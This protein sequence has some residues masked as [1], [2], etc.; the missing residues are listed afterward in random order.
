MK[1]IIKYILV[2]VMLI[3]YASAYG[4]LPG[5]GSLEEAGKK[6]L[7]V[8]ME[9]KKTEQLE[10]LKN[11]RNT[12]LDQK[13]EFTTQVEETLNELQ[14]QEKLLKEQ[15]VKDADN[16][17]LLK[18]S[19]LINERQSTLRKQLQIRDQII[20]T[21]DQHIKI[22]DEYLTDAQFKRYEAKELQVGDQL[23]YS[24][25]TLQRLYNLSVRQQKHNDQLLQKDKQLTSGLEGRKRAAQAT[26]DAFKKKQEEYDQF[27]QRNEN[28]AETYELNFEQRKELFDVE[29][30]LFEDRK[31]LD[32]LQQNDIEQQLAML[33][34][35]EFIGKFHLDLIR[36]WLRRV[37]NAIRI[38]ESEILSDKDKVER[39]H[40]ELYEAKDK[41]RYDRDLLIA[42][43]KKAEEKR[44]TISKQKNI[45][46]AQNIDD[47]SYEP[48]QSAEAYVSFLE[49]A[50]ANS[51]YLLL[52]RKIHLQD[53]LLLLEDEKDRNEEIKVE[54]KESFYI[55]SV[56]RYRSEDD[57]KQELKSYD[58]PRAE[59]QAN[60][61][62]LTEKR[63]STEAQLEMQKRALEN[64]KKIREQIEQNK[65]GIFKD[66]Q[67]DY[68]R[69]LEL[70]KLSERN[71]K[72]QVEIL[73]KVLGNYTD[74]LNL[75]TDMER[76]IQFISSELSSMALWQRPEVAIAWSDIQTILPSIQ[77][78][79]ND[80]QT[81]ILD[82]NI[83]VFIQQFMNHFN[84]PWDIVL[85]IIN[86]CILLGAFIVVRYYLPKVSRRLKRNPAGEERVSTFNL[87]IAMICDFATTYFIGLSVWLI[88]FILLQFYTVSN[89]YYYVL[90]YL[91][92]IP[93]LL[94]HGNRFIAFFRRFN[95]EYGYTFVAEDFESRITLVLSTLL[96]STIII[97]FFK[98]AFILAYYGKTK[99]P[100]ILMALNFIIFQIS[101]ILVLSKEQILSIIPENRAIWEWIREQ[102]DTYYYII[103]IFVIAMI[104]MSNPYVGFGFLVRHIIFR[105]LQTGLIV[106]VLYQLHVWFKRRI[107]TIFF[108][109]DQDVVRERF[110]QAKTW[111]GA[112]V[113]GLF[114]VFMFAGI[115]LFSRIWEW[116]E[117]LA[118]IHSWKD[119]KLLLDTPFMFQDTTAPIS[120]FS[121][122]KIMLFLII[123][124]LVSFGMNQFVL[125]KIF[126]VLLVD[127]GVQNAV[128]SIMRY[129]IIAAS[130]I[131]G[132]ESVG[133]HQ[134]VT[135]LLGALLVSLGWII[136][137][138]MGD[139]IAYFVILVQ[140]PIKIG[141][142]IYVDHESMGVVRKITA[143]SVVLRRRNSTTIVI[144]NSKVVNHPIVNWNYV[145]SFIAFDDI[146][147]TISYKED[148]MRVRELFMKVLDESPYILKSPRPIV[149]LEAFGDF[150]FTFLIRGFVSSNYT[151]EQWE[152]AS[153]VR[154]AMV[155]ALRNNNIEI[156]LPARVVFNRAD[157]SVS[158]PDSIALGD[159]TGMPE[160]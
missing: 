28:F 127:A 36:E 78:F 80:L 130:I 56:G 144:P 60:A 1:A 158:L 65:D 58:S 50:Y 156:A 66:N 118:E 33:K 119:I 92:S 116:P 38:S 73:S 157:K 117:R 126:N 86:I 17:F 64:I 149:R 142:Y 70:V 59:I 29:R 63:T 12:L 34:T 110:S 69:A 25:E 107:G 72:Q 151:L 129:I 85:L 150:G 132:L 111:Y 54:V 14:A 112:S 100:T 97:F 102:V 68:A 20:S 32:A 103:L 62:L 18:K 22:I 24:Y 109:I 136:K 124:V 114:L 46:L 140:R 48:R 87:F 47:W 16:D 139:F 101:L 146:V 35:Q 30:K 6:I 143:R 137:D 155:L 88:L 41:L 76:Q 134:M 96:Y 7:P 19:T 77:Q 89:V 93:Y 115:I 122:L 133:L 131:I 123:G 71:I 23:V 120:T 90:F 39:K 99:L 44:D 84:E 74:T 105:S 55:L 10:T 40:R 57:V 82:F 95:T 152:I 67:S 79:L 31:E 108:D 5:F 61:S 104:V 148:P 9:R 37:K 83:S 141:D 15:V 45:A 42:E 8:D 125:G 13:Q 138:P 75:I 147:I 81:Y 94:Y 153:D 91:I 154:L 53:T 26:I 128:S 27:Q 3:P 135:I 11:E 106:F 113:I 49:T 51:Q 160:K 159:R 52:K 43:Q 4:S 98:E 121:L 21:I 145:R 2:I